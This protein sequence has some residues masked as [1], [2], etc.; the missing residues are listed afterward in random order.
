MGKGHGH[1]PRHRDGS[2]APLTEQFKSHGEK[3][4]QL[5]SR[6][7]TFA[8]ASALA[9]AAPAIAAH[10]SASAAARAHGLVDGAAARAVRRASADAFT[11][12]S[13]VVDAKGTEHV[14]FTRSYRG[15]P[16]IGGDFVLHSRN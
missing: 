9:G 12:G 2:V 15:L 4:M 7:L 5:H 3:F 14:R 1:P 6:L 10:G 16:V 8:I 11:A 13:V